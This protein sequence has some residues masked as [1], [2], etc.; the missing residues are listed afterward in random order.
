MLLLLDSK[1]DPFIDL[2]PDDIVRVE[3]H[4][5]DGKQLLVDEFRGN[6]RI[7]AMLCALLTEVQVLDDTTWRVLTERTIDNA[8]GVLLD[9]L[10]AIVG[11]D[12]MEL[13][14]KNYRAVI[15]GRI[16]AN[17]S[18][19]S[20]EDLYLIVTATLSNPTTVVA[21]LRR[22]GT[23]AFTLTLRVPLDFDEGILNGLIQDGK[24]A[25]VRA[26]V[27]VPMVAVANTFS[28]GPTSPTRTLNP[29][30]GFADTTGGTG[31]Q[32]ARAMDEGT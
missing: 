30:Q 13:S 9:D 7:E 27:V 31:G 3:S 15:R 26:V 24:L 20:V 19:G 17:S 14:D 5:E 28:F 6:P 1:P 2:G 18:D 4:C 32:F 21:K 16:R 23:A 11:Q 25:G 8:R 12:R 29:A 10:G 22:Y